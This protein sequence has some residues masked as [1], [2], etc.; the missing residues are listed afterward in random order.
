MTKQEFGKIAKGLKAVF[1]K[2]DFL[3]DDY[4]MEVWYMAL[5]DIPYNVA[6]AAA[7]VYIATNHFEPK[8]ADIRE[9][10]A[11]IT[12]KE[13][14]SMSAAQAFAIYWD[15]LCDS[16]YNAKERFDKLPEIIKRIAGSPSS[17]HDAAISE[18]T[19]QSVER[20]LFEKKYNI[21]LERMKQEALIPQRVKDLIEQSIVARIA[22]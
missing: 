12:E 7:Q 21:E 3:P 10:S 1:T 22:G 6:S 11:K 4:A 18:D 9:I 8:P 5:S 14:M 17:M 19:N 2:Q 15:A 16:G 20:A 13:E